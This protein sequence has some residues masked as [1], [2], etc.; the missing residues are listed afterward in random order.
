MTIVT[1]SGH[2]HIIPCVIRA[3]D[4]CLIWVS[5]SRHALI[6]VLRYP[7]CLRKP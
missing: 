7:D 3:S 2:W 5:T 4:S 6:L 1:R